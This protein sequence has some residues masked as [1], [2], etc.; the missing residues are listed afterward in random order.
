MASIPQKQADRFSEGCTDD[1]LNKERN[2]QYFLNM[3]ISPD[4]Q[5]LI[6]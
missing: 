5:M 1:S 6:G 2:K 3:D 4:L